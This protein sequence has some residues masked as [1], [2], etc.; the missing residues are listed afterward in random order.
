[1]AFVEFVADSDY[2]SSGAVRLDVYASQREGISRSR[3]KNGISSILV[4][5]KPA[6]LSFKLKGGELVR[7]EWQDEE[8]HDIQAENIPLDVIFENEDVAVINKPQGMVT[9]PGAGNWHGTLANA[10]MY[11]FGLEAE[12][13]LRPGIVHRLD[14]DTSGLIITAKNRAAE[15]FLHD[16]FTGRRVFKEYIAIV[17]GH[18][19]YRSG[20]IQ[21]RIVRDP[22]NRKRFTTTNDPDKGKFAWTKYRCIAVYGDY[23]LVKLRLKTGRTHQIRVHLKSIGCPILGDPVYARKDDRFP[24]ATL[25]LHAFRLGIAVEQGGKRVFFKAPVPGRFLLTEKKL[26]DTWQ[27]SMAPLSPQMIQKRAEKTEGKKR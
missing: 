16:E 27:K 3:L 20:N 22:K 10:L 17:K 12:S 26:K 23:S 2:L 21:S 8:S 14:K 11:K 19:P 4:N 5:D 9:H 7:F 24:N 13:S 1:M 15:D 25:M 6:K 18:P